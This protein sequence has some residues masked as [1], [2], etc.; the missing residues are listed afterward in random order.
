MNKASSSLL[1]PPVAIV[2][3]GSLSTVTGESLDNVLSFSLKRLV[4]GS[5]YYGAG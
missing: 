5:G 2:M 1:L 3:A 4:A